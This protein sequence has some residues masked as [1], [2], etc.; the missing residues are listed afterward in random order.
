MNSMNENECKHGGTGFHGEFRHRAKFQ[1]EQNECRDME[2]ELVKEAVQHVELQQR[3]VTERIHER[4]YQGKTVK[5]LKL[6]I[7]TILYNS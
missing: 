7:H 3:N 6:Y 4:V 2:Q 5:H 1:Q